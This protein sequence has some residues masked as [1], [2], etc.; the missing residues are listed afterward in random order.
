[1]LLIF[2]VPTVLAAPGTITWYKF[3]KKF[4]ADHYVSDSAFGTVPATQ[5]TAATTV[6]SRSCGG[7]DGE[8]HIGI[9]EDAIQTDHH[10]V[11]AKAEASAADPKW[12]IVAELPNA[13]EGGPA[14]LDGEKGNPLTFGGYFRLWDEGHAHGSAADSNPHHILELHPSWAFGSDSSNFVHD[15]PELV[16]SIAGYSG[17]GAS[18][19]KPLFNTLRSGAWL[20]A[21]QDDD[22]VY[23]QLR[24]SSNFH[25]LPVKINHVKSITG[26]HELSVNVFSD[27]NF[28]NRVHENLRV[29]TST[30]SA[31]DDDLDSVS[32]GDQMFLFGFFSVNL[33]KAVELSHGA[34]TQAGAVPVPDA[35]EFFVFGRATQSAVSS[36]GSN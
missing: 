26:G 24:E 18:K 9:P 34:H 21:W 1:M 5:W 16:K 31:F 30:N 28:S 25:Q 10:P 8:L 11:S 35:L 3:S 15:G 22:F 4:I 14:D 29:I 36:C 13:S 2:S 27:K 7:S 23:V 19:F 32:T 20:N 33:Q 6:H 17:Y 12:G